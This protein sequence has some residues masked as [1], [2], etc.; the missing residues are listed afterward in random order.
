VQAIALIALPNLKEKQ[1]AN[2]LY[3]V[4][5]LEFISSALANFSSQS[6]S[7]CASEAALKGCHF[8]SR[9]YRAG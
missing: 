7:L 4:P 5:A 8:R 1:G 6:G 3:P 9:D 2:L